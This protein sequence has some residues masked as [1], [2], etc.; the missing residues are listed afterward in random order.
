MSNKSKPEAAPEVQT[1]D[2]EEALKAAEAA[3]ATTSETSESSEPP[4]PDDEQGGPEG[5]AEAAEGPIVEDYTDAPPASDDS[6]PYARKPKVE[7]T[8]T[9]SGAVIETYL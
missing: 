2:K 1:L 8:E 5:P 6:G 3:E 4:T 7:K 9:D